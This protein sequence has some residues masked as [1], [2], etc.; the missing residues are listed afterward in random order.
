MSYQVNASDAS[1]HHT[2]R[3]ADLDPE[4]NDPFSLPR[5]AFLEPVKWTVPIS[6]LAAEILCIVFHIGKH[7]DSQTWVAKNH[8]SFEVLV[9]HVC[10]SWRFIT[11]ED[12][13]LWVDVRIAPSVPLSMVQAYVQ[14]SKTVPISLVLGCRATIRRIPKLEPAHSDHLCTWDDKSSIDLLVLHSYRWQ[15]LEISAYCRSEVYHILRTLRSLAAPRLET[16][17]ISFHANPPSI[18]TRCSWFHRLPIFEGGAP[19]LTNIQMHGIGLGSFC[20]PLSAVTKVTM[21][22]NAFVPSSPLSWH[23]FRDT[24][25]SARSLQVLRI[26]G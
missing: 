2:I 13:F 16:L 17:R 26:V 15:S 23:L 5:Q 18:T 8:L 10:S 3:P 9:S 6:Y 11:L 25:G 14:R 20:P 7:A 12:P 24:L 19:I 21:V 4:L 1:I 22:N